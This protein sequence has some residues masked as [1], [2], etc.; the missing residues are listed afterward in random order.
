MSR[1]LAFLLLLFASGW[2]LAAADCNTCH[3]DQAAKLPK[4]A[5]SG[6]T[7][8]TCHENHEN[9]PHPANL[10]KP[11]TE[12]FRKALPDQCGMCH[13]D[14]SDQYKTSVHGQA[15]AEG[16]GQAPVCSDCHG[17]HDILRHTNA[18]SPV[19][20]THVRDTCGGC[21]GNVQLSRQMKMPED[22]LVSY[23]ESFHGLAASAG[24]QTVANC[25]S[26]HGVHHILPSS[27]VKSTV[28]PKHLPVTCGQCHPGAGKRFA[29]T[30]IHLI[31][32][33]ESVSVTW[34]RRVYGI[35]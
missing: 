14:I 28:N 27:D 23:D 15:V 35:L 17:S 25:A 24:N 33:R 34:V 11:K 18:D 29:I 16:I 5:H 26:C 3:T 19:S 32:G 22:R 1:S 6:L 13:G 21:H 20:R 12:A 31:Q 30:Q 7:C 2:T 9:F 10:P 8:D 4:S